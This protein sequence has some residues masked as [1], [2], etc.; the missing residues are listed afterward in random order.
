MKFINYYDGKLTGF[1]RVEIP[2]D[3]KGIYIN[4]RIIGYYTNSYFK[5]VNMYNRNI[6]HYEGKDIIKCKFSDKLIGILT[7]KSLKIK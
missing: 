2:T 4:K 6:F 7:K 3:I 1:Q 5:M